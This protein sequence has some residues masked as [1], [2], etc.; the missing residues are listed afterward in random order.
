MIKI[1]NDLLMAQAGEKDYYDKSM[2]RAFSLT[3]YSPGEKDG[4]LHHL[5]GIFLPL[6]FQ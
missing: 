4:N 6:Q 1:R 2:P 3:E 5:E